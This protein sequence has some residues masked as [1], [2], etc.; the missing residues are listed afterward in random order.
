MNN[1]C[2]ILSDTICVFFT[3]SAWFFS[4]SRCSGFFFTSIIKPFSEINKINTGFFYLKHVL[5]LLIV[6]QSGQVEW[7][8]Q[9]KET[10]YGPEVTNLKTWPKIIR[11]IMKRMNIVFDFLL[12]ESGV[13]TITTVM[14]K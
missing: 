7:M 8:K 9:M 1:A 11:I 10:L 2:D 6:H 14:Q 3:P 13:I 5:I 4:R 12:M